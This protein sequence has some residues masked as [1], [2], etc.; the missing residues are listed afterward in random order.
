MVT[1]ELVIISI[2]VSI[3][4]VISIVGIFLALLP[5]KSGRRSSKEV[6][7]IIKEIN[8]ITNNKLNATI[9]NNTKLYVNATEILERTYK[10]NQCN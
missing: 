4:L 6:N 8:T 2:I 3:L 9:D 1:V 10:D 5:K 7:L